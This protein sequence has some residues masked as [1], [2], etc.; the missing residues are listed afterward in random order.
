MKDLRDSNCV[1]RKLGWG[2]K[3][4][5]R[6]GSRLKQPVH[7]QVRSRRGRGRAVPPD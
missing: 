7:L 4:L 5:G 3:L 1:G 2:V 6:G